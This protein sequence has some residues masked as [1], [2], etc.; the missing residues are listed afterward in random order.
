MSFEV[1]VKNG[2]RVA[3]LRILSLVM[4]GVLV[5]FLNWD[6]MADTLREE[7]AYWVFIAFTGIFV[8]FFALSF[9]IARRP[10]IKADGQ[11]VT[12]YPLWRR[13]RT[14]ALSEITSR[15]E[16]FDYSDPKKAALAGAVGGGLLAYAVTRR[17][18]AGLKPPQATIYTYY[19]G[20]RK[21]FT[22]SSRNAQNLE[23]FNQLVTAQLAERPPQADPHAKPSRLP[24]LCAIGIPAAC[25][26][27]VV[28][29]L[30]L[31]REQQD[32]LAGTAWIANNDGSYWVFE[33]DHTFH[34]YQTK[35][36]TDDNYFAGTYE[37]HM[38]SDGIK[39]LTTELSQYAV[40][41]E[42]ILGVIARAPAYNVD[43]F[44][45]FSTTNQSF[46]RNGEEQLD[47]PNVSSYFGFL[48]LDGTYLDI[49]NMTTG[50]YYGFTKE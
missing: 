37:F 23:Q 30:L 14:V 8:L 12:F 35:G 46:L 20:A 21:L 7:G 31:P 48:L 49:A 2:A 41:E 47:Q 28:T 6:L 18:A 10:R 1:R 25:A 3:A 33:P 19:S 45:C 16:K 24:L 32:F 17:D 13:S 27:T 26:L 34:W 40:T 36:I 15:G 44:V 42:E 29:F 50:N 39:Y 38:G 4:I 22:I 9:Y 11:T 43:N 5:W